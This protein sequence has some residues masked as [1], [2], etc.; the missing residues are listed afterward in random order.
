MITQANEPHY[1]LQSLSGPQ[2]NF[3][4]NLICSIFVYIYI[5]SRSRVMII[6]ELRPPYGPQSNVLNQFNLLYIYIYL[7]LQQI[8][9]YVHPS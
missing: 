9:N 8:K 1:G 7:Y 3:K 5:Y 2:R 6:Y 4:I